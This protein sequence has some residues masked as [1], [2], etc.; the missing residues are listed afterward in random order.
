VVLQGAARNLLPYATLHRNIWLAQRRAHPRHHAGPPRPHPGPG[1]APRTR[2]RAAG[3]PD[4][5]RPAAGRALRRAGPGPPSG[6][7]GR[8][9]RSGAWSCRR[10]RC[11][12]TASISPGRAA[13]D[14][15]RNTGTPVSYANEADSTTSVRPGGAGTGPLTASP[16]A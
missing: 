14:T 15:S 8:P 6:P 7:A 13:T 4:A 11:Q 10:R 12:V 2:A 9:S 1:R 16:G 5:G 3:R